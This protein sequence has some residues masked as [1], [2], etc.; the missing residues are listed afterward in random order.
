MAKQKVALDCLSYHAAAGDD[1][2]EVLAKATVPKAEE[3]RLDRWL[4]LIRCRCY[5]E[6][7]IFYSWIGKIGVMNTPKNNFYIARCYTFSYKFNDTNMDVFNT[8]KVVIRMFMEFGLIQEYHIPY[9][10]SRLIY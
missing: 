9:K 2:T 6:Y 1:D 3:F 7:T 4:D 5:N 10:V 8:Y